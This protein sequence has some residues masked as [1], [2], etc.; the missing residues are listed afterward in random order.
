MDELGGFSLSSG[1][2][3]ANF[4]DAD[5]TRPS[6]AYMEAFGGNQDSI[7]GIVQQTLTRHIS[8]TVPPS[9]RLSSL[10]NWRK[11]LR[12]MM[13]RQNET[14]LQFLFRPSTEHSVLGP[15]EQALRRYALRQ[16]I[17]VNSV[18]TVGQLIEDL[19]GSTVSNEIDNCILSK[20]KSS[21]TEI[22]SQVN[23]LIEMYKE[24]GEKLL[25]CENQ[26]KLRLDKMDKI[27]K[28]VSMIF[29]LQTNDAMASLVSS[30]EKYLEISFRDMGIEDNYK[31]LLSL[32]E[33]HITLRDAIQVFKAGSQCENL[34]PICLNEQV[35]M[36][37]VPCGHT[38]CATCIR[39]MNQDCGMCRGK[40]RERLKL[41][42]F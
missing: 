39:R 26:L 30:L 11:R 10:T 22:H 37:A 12:E 28:R 7:Q 41:F 16:D 36:A 17:D 9:P 27:Q 23:A 14:V 38:F 20:G 34:C 31:N 13:V 15:V 4:L 29:E 35:N 1:F 3:S 25:E 21:L 2:S 19:S 24:T 40:I 18:K 42:F 8:E 5:D 32:Y 6:G 33:K